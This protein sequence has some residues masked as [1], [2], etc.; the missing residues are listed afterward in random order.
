ME[1]D[2][3]SHMPVPRPC[4]AMPWPW[5]VAFITAWHGRGMACVNHVRPH[6]VNQIGKTQTK[7]LAA[8]HGRGTAWYVWISFKWT[9]LTV[10]GTYRLPWQVVHNFPHYKASYS[11]TARLS[12][13]Q[14]RTQDFFSGGVQQILLRIEGRENGDLGAV[15]PQSEVPL[16]L[17]M[18]ETHIL[19]RLLRMYSPRNW[20]FGSALA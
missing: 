4:C 11:S 2:V 12:I 5:E 14:W 3:N 1:A 18:N 16:N 10:P 6:C 8:R 19:I 13:W 9:Q 20:E 17:Q 15:T 7:H